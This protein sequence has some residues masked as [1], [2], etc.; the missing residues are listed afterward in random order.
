MVGV[1]CV[2]GLCI[3]NC[4]TVR[5]I[6]HDKGDTVVEVNTFTTE[7]ECKSY[8]KDR[9]RDNRYVMVCVVGV[10]CGDVYP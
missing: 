3:E 10:V 1:V 2:W 6:D 7:A 9:G 4:D 8:F 5:D